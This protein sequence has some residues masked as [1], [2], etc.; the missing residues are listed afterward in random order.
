[1]VDQA[2]VG[3]EQPHPQQA[4][5]HVGYQPGDQQHRPQC[6]RSGQTVHQRRQ[7]QCQQGL[8]HDVHQDVVAGDLQCVPELLVADQPAVVVPADEVG[9]GDEAVVGERVVDAPHGRIRV[10]EREA[11]QGRRQEQPRR[12]PVVAGPASPARRRGPARRR[13]GTWM[14]WRH[15]R[16]CAHG[17]PR[18]DSRRTSCQWGTVDNILM[19]KSETL[20]MLSHNDEAGRQARHRRAADSPSV[21]GG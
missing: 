5:G 7:D 12:L 15:R 10:E 17:S 13:T 9:R 3:V 21:P 19:S 2:E 6:H 4:H 11:E 20:S 18:R 14:R 1:M 16:V 8:R